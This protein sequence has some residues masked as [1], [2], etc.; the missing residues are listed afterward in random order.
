MAE[1]AVS[2]YFGSGDEQESLE[3][4]VESMTDES[5]T[6]SILRASDSDSSIA[7][8]H[9]ASGKGEFM[10]NLR[11]TGLEMTCPAGASNLPTLRR[12]PERYSKGLDM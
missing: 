4:S 3:G 6:C 2:Q 5:A 10:D 12:R 7:T 8:R 11:T 9:T 1:R